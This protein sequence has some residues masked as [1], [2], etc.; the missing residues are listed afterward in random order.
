M[1][2]LLPFL[3]AS[4]IALPAVAEEA[5]DCSKHLVCGEWRYM[6]QSPSTGTIGSEA[7]D[8]VGLAIIALFT[9]VFDTMVSEVNHWQETRPIDKVEVTREENE[10]C[11]DTGMC[12]T[13]ITM[14]TISHKREK[15]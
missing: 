11:D 9:R 15:N 3:L 5:N 13:T 10:V 12:V 7:D 2:K 14:K 8:I 4:A 1:R 6:D